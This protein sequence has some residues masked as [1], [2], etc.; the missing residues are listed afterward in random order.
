MGKINIRRHIGDILVNK[1]IV[2]EEQL[3]K[4][5]SILSEEPKESNI[6]SGFGAEPAPDHEG[7][8]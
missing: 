7:N 4:G 2:T 6:I 1:G 5:L 3:Q 8:C